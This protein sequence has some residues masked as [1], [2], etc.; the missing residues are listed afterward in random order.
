[1]IRLWDTCVAE[2]AACFEDFHVL[3]CA[4]FLKHSSSSNQAQVLK[5]GVGVVG[6]D[7]NTSS[8]VRMIC[9]RFI[10][11]LPAFLVVL[12]VWLITYRHSTPPPLPMS[13]MQTIPTSEWDP[14][15][16][17]TMLS[18]AFVLSTLH[19]G[20]QAHL[21][22]VENQHQQQELGRYLYLQ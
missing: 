1:M 22:Y 11:S 13:F 12:S 7:S 18:E 6:V 9:R 17:E 21:T 2:E 8:F 10:S 20:S 19:Q 3:L 16:V 15:E 5:N 14:Q 4:A